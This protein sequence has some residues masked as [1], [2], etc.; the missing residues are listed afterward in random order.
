MERYRICGSGRNGMGRYRI[1]RRDG[2]ERY[3]TVKDFAERYSGIGYLAA[4]GTVWN[5][6]QIGP[7]LKRYAMV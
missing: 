4:A 1:L 6:M 3:S 5:G 2:M 7:R